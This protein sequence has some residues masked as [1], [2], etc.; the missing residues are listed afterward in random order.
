MMDDKNE[1]ENY[2]LYQNKSLKRIETDISQIILDVQN[3]IKDKEDFIYDKTL[4]EKKNF[5]ITPNSIERIKKISY[6]IS[7]GVPILLEGPSGTSKTFSTE[8]SCL[9]AKPKNH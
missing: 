6:Y 7:R 2:Y 5:I 4:L 1:K 3:H 9:I 8:F